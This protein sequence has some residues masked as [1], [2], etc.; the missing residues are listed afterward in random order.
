M[1]L[2]EK[3]PEIVFRIINK[4]GEAVGSYSQAYCDEYD[5]ESVQQA[6]SANVHGEFKNK[7][8]YKI[9]KYHVMYKLLDPDCD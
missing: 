2:K 3:K 9:A 6:R 7:K 5:F 8:K 1:K 4:N